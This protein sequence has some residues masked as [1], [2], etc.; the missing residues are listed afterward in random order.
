MTTELRELMTSAADDLPPHDLAGRAMAGARRRRQGRFAVVGSIAAV[1]VLVAGAVVLGPLQRT[2]DEPRP[3]DVASLP[4][5]LPGPSGLPEL[6]GGAMDAASVAYVVDDRLV[7][8]DATDGSGSVY[9]GI[10]ELSEVAGS[11]MSAMPLRPYQ[12]RL[13]PDG[14]TALVAMRFDSSQRLL[15][16]RLA[17]LDVATAEV[18]VEDLQL[19]DAYAESAWL[20]Y[21]LMAWAPDSKRAYCV[22]VDG[23]SGAAELGV[24]SLT[25]GR[26]PMDTFYSRES[27]LAPAQISAGVADVAVQ[28]EPGGTW[29]LLA[30]D[31][32]V[33]T[34]LAAGDAFALSSRES[35]GFAVTRDGTYGIRAADESEE[36]MSWSPLPD[37]PASA[38]HAYGDDY[39]L[40]SRPE[41]A[42]P[43]EPAP[44]A[45][46][47]AHLLTEGR[48]PQVLTTFPAGT[49]STSFAA[50]PGA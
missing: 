15:G 41:S 38:L 12:V 40:V 42:L 36:R 1:T 32:S 37:G 31:G 25:I 8:V 4:S 49:T 14:T 50:N 34:P 23:D 39:L 16:I 6:T 43:G 11:G 35:A 18:S 5:E 45:Q 9:N 26:A 44:P 24:W 47:L 20:E 48:D 10:S 30:D 27:K 22:C 33:S 2:S 17:V 7:L 3:Q 19:T 28:L 29:A 21:N 13:S 46:L